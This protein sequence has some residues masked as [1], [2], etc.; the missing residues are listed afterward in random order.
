MCIYMYIFIYLLH[1]CVVTVLTVPSIHA[2]KRPPMIITQPESV[3]VFS[4]EDFVMS[5][6]ASGNPQPM[7]VSTHKHTRTHTHLSKSKDATL[8]MG[9]SSHRLSLQTTENSDLPSPCSADIHILV[10]HESTASSSQSSCFSK[11]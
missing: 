4:V 1:N 11:G 5:C 6:E 9:G 3:T 10:L 2:V 8:V 7:L